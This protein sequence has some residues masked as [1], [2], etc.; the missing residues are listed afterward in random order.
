MS[1]GGVRWLLDL[2]NSRLKCARLQADG[3]AGEVLAL[4]HEDAGALAALIAH[5]GAAGPDD[6]AWLASVAAPS[7]TTAVESALQAAG[8][9]VHRVRTQAACAGLRIAYA[10]PSRLGVD[11]FL[12]LLAASARDDGPW[13]LVSAGSALTVD[14]LGADGVH[15]GGAIAPTPEAMRAALAAR[16]VQLDLPAGT[17]TDFADDTADAIASG[18]EAAALGLVERSLRAARRRLGVSPALLVTGGGS[19][20]LEGVDHAPT[21]VV[22]ALVL[23]G[24]AAFV[25]AQ[26]A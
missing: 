4:A 20:W 21:H 9:R 1:T 26:D 7:R 17:A 2:G 12:A 14:L 10:D 18:C 19:A 25:R 3:R 24:L 22:P 5:L 6:G 16:F 23:D 15:V 11:R 13:L 8:W